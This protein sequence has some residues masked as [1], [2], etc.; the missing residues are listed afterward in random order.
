MRFGAVR[1]VL[2]SRI[3]I[4]AVPATACAKPGWRLVTRPAPPREIVPIASR[5][6]MVSPPDNRPLLPVR[7]RA[8]R[9]SIHV[10]AARLGH[11]ADL[12]EPL[13][14]RRHAEARPLV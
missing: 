11:F 2:M 14:V 8:V 6:F 3:L 13:H 4:G 12:R 1:I 7:E 10:P 5:R 9:A